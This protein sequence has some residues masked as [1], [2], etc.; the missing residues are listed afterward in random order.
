M[1]DSNVI[2]SVGGDIS[3]FV[4]GLAA[5]VN[6]TYSY[7]TN[8][9]FYV[10]TVPA[11][12]KDYADRY[13]MPALQWLDG[14]VPYWHAQETGIL[15]T[16]IASR[17]ITGLTKQVVG[18]RLVFEYKSKDDAETSDTLR[19]VSK[20][21]NEQK[22]V[23]AVYAAIGWSLA[24]GTSLIKANI[25][26]DQRI[27]WEAC[28][29]DNC[30]YLTDFKGE[31][32]EATFKIRGYTDTR[33]GHNNEQFYLTEHRY[34]ETAKQG[35]VYY[36]KATGKSEPLVTKGQRTAMV[37]Y[38]VYRTNGT[39]QKAY[40]GSGPNSLPWDN[41]PA[42]IREAIKRDYKALAVGKP[43]KIGL[44]TLG[45]EVLTNGNID[46]SV[47][48]GANLGESL[49][50]PIESD[51]ITYEYAYSCRIRDMHL[52]KGKVYLPKSLS[53]GDLGGVQTAKNGILGP[54]PGEDSAVEMVKGLDPE[55]QKAIVQQFELRAEEWQ[56]IIDDSLKAIAV[57]WGMSPKILA[58]YLAQGTA[59]QTA[60]QIDSEDDM[61][62]AF[63]SLCRSYFVDAL[64]RLLETTMNFYGKAANITM[65][66]ASPS[67][68][69]KDRLLKRVENQ[70]NDGLMDI[71][72]AVRAMNPDLDEDSLRAKISKAEEAVAAKA[73]DVANLDPFGNLPE[74]DLSGTS[75]PATDKA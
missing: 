33:E 10:A 64:N 55:G 18:E 3:K 61:S 42:N 44:P 58:S 38:A 73:K 7:A 4:S 60:T 71:E 40:M 26:S 65:R 36:D 27:W 70:L 21:A 67:L 23:K 20:W 63:I 72:E 24:V 46:L 22:A 39:M 37:E 19:F 16:R 51:I 25:T 31:V 57:K 59:Q 45:V 34:Y 32:I 15:S 2:N 41:I 1:G 75:A 43:M 52:G 9:S 62:I 12:M 54:M 30:N 35:K 29:L 17:L 11:Y 47:P 48:N 8:A 53:M 6:K 74:Q 14:Y 5:A 69:N 68:V 13:L 49:I 66:F 50:I 28:R 56:R